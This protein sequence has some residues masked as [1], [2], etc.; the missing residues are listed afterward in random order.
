MDDHRITRNIGAAENV[1]IQHQQL[2]DSSSSVNSI[3]STT[4]D[5][6]MQICQDHSMCIS[7]LIQISTFSLQLYTVV[8][9]VE[10]KDFK[11]LQNETVEA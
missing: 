9:F 7:C 2:L 1:L 3:R 10:C 4:D 8:T 5:N 6:T 11:G